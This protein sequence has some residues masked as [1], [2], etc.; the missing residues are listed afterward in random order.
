MALKYPESQHPSFDLND[1]GESWELF[2]LSRHRATINKILKR[3]VHKHT[4]PEQNRVNPL[5]Q[6][7]FDDAPTRRR[8]K[9]RL[10]QIRFHPPAQ[11]CLSVDLF[12]L[13]YPV[14]MVD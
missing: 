13:H 8:R 3:N 2:F 14:G 5:H 10:K 9:K 12:F 1:S 6:R 4:H 11:K 7:H